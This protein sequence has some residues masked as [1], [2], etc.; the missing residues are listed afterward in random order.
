MPSLTVL[1]RS[2]VS[3]HALGLGLTLSLMGEVLDL[4]VD[5]GAA[6]YRRYRE[7]LRDL[8]STNALPLVTVLAARWFT[9][10]R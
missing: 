8:V 6:G 7:S 10:R 5:I 1:R 9:R 2:P 4:W 3:F